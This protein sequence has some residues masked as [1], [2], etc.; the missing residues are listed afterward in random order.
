MNM[1]FDGLIQLKAHGKKT[2]WAFY[3]DDPWLKTWIGAVGA[4]SVFET[5]GPNR[6]LKIQEWIQTQIP[7]NSIFPTAFTFEDETTGNIAAGTTFKPKHILSGE[8]QPIST[9]DTLL[10]H[11]LDIT[12]LEKSFIEPLNGYI[13]SAEKILQLID[14]NIIAKVILA[15]GIKIKTVQTLNPWDVAIALKHTYPMCQIIVWITPYGEHF[16]AATPERLVLKHN[17]SIETEA[18]AGTAPRGETPELDDLIGNKLLHDTKEI[19]E[20]TVVCQ[21]IVHHLQSLGLDPTIE[22]RTLRKLPFL[23]HVLTPIHAVGHTPILELVHHLH[24][25]AAVCGLP[26]S[27]AK[28]IIQSMEKFQRGFYAGAFGFAKQTGEGQFCVGLRGGTL[29]GNETIF[30][31][32][33]GIVKQANP[34]AELNE[35]QLKLNAFSSLGFSEV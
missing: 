8:L 25:T 9:S 19:S 30:F 15:C 20:H 22:P 23:Q 34:Q 16:V 11:A 35:I 26:T 28:T 10:N 2:D 7:S 5:D 33:S 14:N 4:E 12:I 1:S 24:P 27:K 21:Q 17:Y 3:L 29:K 31:A 32:G 13:K 18:L 6:A